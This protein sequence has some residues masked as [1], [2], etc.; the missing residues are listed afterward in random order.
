MSTRL[1]VTEGNCRIDLEG[2]HCQQV[3]IDDYLANKDY[4]K[5]RNTQVINLCRDFSYL[6]VGYYCS[7]LAEARNHR[8][9]PSVKTMLDLSSKS[10]YSLDMDTL[11][12]AVEKGFKRHLLS[13]EDRQFDL[14]VFF[15]FTEHEPFVDLA[16]QLFETFP[17]PLLSVRFVRDKHWRIQRLRP[18]AFNG[19]SVTRRDFFQQALGRYLIKRWRGARRVKPTRYDL[20][21]LHDPNEALP[22]SDHRALQAFIKAGKKCG[23]AVELIEKKDYSRLAEYDALFIRATTNIRHYTYRFAKK[24]ESEGMVVMDDPVSI[25]RCT[26]KVYLAELL[27]THKVPVPKTVIVGR[28]DIDAAEHAIGYPMVLKVP[29]GSF[30]KGVFKIEDRHGL[31]EITSLLFK[32]SELI[33]AQEYF[34]TEF[35]W[36]IGVLDRKPLFASQYFMS[37]QH[38]QIVNYDHHGNATEGGFYTWG[39]E[40]VPVD[41]VNVALKAANLIGDGLYGVDLKQ[42][43]KGVYVIEVNDNPNL[44]SGVEDIVLK[45]QLYQTIMTEFLRRLE[46]RHGRGG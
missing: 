43:D 4:F 19:L 34:Y 18:L 37:K 32:S 8:V 14:D 38:W 2:L 45:D 25:L 46:L 35:D 24:A 31:N 36:R 12:R 33:L 40:Q 42:S 17:C 1:I 15:G 23:I 11:E 29:D 27:Q 3:D 9:I 21:I 26:N 28:R 22:P 13:E 41:V 16:R 39:V 5:L 44:E 30:S 20:A 10:M 6:S 7:L